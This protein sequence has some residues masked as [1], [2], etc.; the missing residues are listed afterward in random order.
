MYSVTLYRDFLDPP[1]AK[2]CLARGVT[3][4]VRVPKYNH[5]CFNIRFFQ[6]FLI[7]LYS[8]S[9]SSRGRSNW[10]IVVLVDV[11]RV[12]VFVVVLMV[13]VV[14]EVAVLVVI[15]VDVVL[16]VVF[17]VVVMAVVVTMM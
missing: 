17:A 9:W 13:V 6:C 7:F 4:Y 2:G 11:L 10:A 15:V 1:K 8:S 16:I 3:E 14:S 12:R 5:F